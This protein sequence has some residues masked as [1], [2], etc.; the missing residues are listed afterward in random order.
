MGC[1]CDKNIDCTTSAQC[2]CGIVLKLYDASNVLVD[3][4]TGIGWTDSFTNVVSYQFEQGTV[5]PTGTLIMSY[6]STINRWELIHNDTTLYLPDTSMLFGT[7]TTDSLC[8]DT[9]CDLDLSCNT[10][11]FQFVGTGIGGIEWQG[12]MYNGKKL[13][14]RMFIVERLTQANS[15][16]LSSDNL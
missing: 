12:D 3:T 6:N 16:G 5:F 4:L 1:T 13:Y 10:L 11:E 7:Y 15:S 8:P 14:R 2:V 9:E